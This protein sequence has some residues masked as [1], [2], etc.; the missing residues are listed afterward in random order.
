MPTCINLR[1]RFGKRYRIT[2]DPAHAGEYGEHG[3]TEDAWLQIIEGRAGHVFPW[4][5]ETLAASTNRRGALACKL[6]AVEGA[7]LVQDGTDGATVTFP[8]E[9]FAEVARLLHLRTR[10]QLTPEQK[11]K[12]A[13]SNAAYRFRSGSPVV[14]NLARV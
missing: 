2:H 14:A 12:L 10:R 4:G 11:A 3:R 9:R 1:E 5:G 6:A 13:Q 8:V 7:H